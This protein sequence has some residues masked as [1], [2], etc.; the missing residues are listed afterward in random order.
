M[1]CFYFKTEIKCVHLQEMLFMFVK[2]L[3]IIIVSLQIL[4][5]KHTT[6]NFTLEINN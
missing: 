5:T 2:G 4:K 6:L 1:T 3:N